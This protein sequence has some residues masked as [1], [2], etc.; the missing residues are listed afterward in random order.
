MVYCFAEF[1]FDPRL[2][3]LVSDDDTVSLRPQASRLLEVLITHAPDI[4]DG[5]ELLDEV[6]GR[7]ALSP[8]VVPQAISELRQ[9]LGDH[10]Q[11]P[12][13]IETRHRRGYRFICPV[14]EVD[15]D[16]ESNHGGALPVSASAARASSRSRILFA[17]T[18]VAVLA[19]AAMSLAWWR[20]GADQRWLETTAIPEFERLM[21][22]DM[23]QAWRWLREAR[24]R[25]PGDPL[26]EQLWLDL[27]LP[28]TLV[29]KPEGATVEVLDYDGEPDSWVPLGETPLV[30]VR[31]PLVQMRFHLALDGY[32]ALETAP[33]VLPAAEPFRLHRPGEAPEDMVF[34]PGGTVHYQD[35]VREVPDFWLDRHE[36]T[37]EDYL[38]FVEAGGYERPEYWPQPAKVDGKPLSFEAMVAG[39]V[40]S[41]GS[42]GPATWTLGMYPQGEANRPVEGI[43]WYEAAAYAAFVDKRLPTAFH[44]YRAAG[45]GTLP[46]ANFSDVLGRSN[47]SGRGATDVGELGGQGPYGTQDMAGNV[48]E[49]VATP[50]GELRHINGGSWLSNN[51]RFRD[52]DA[53]PPLERR[54]GFGVRL[55]QQ[56]EPVAPELLANVEFTSDP[57][58]EPVDDETFAIYERQFDYDPS[59][60]EPRVE[61]VD[62]SH[63][64]WRREY[65]SYTGAYG[66]ERKHAQLLLPRH[67]EPP[68][69]VVVHFP[70]GDALLL[71]DSAEAGLNQVELFLRNGRA[72]IYP[73][74]AGTFERREW[75]ATGPASSRDLLVAQVRDLRRS[76]DYLASRP[77]IDSEA[78]LLHGLSYG[79]VRAPFALAVE[80]RIKAA[81]LVSVGYYL[82]DAQLPEVQLQD[83]LPRIRIPVLV[84]NGRDDFTFPLASSQEPFF[85]MLGAAP[86]K[87]VHLLRDWGHIPPY[88]RELVQAQLDWVDRWLGPA[89]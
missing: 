39:L 82:R 61:R 27:T 67:G 84:I 44:W 17:V 74:Y 30:D 13:F 29:S 68:Y 35:E 10:A 18:L 52:P 6:W 76:L 19:V 32:Q 28:V 9:A 87:K 70:G 71:G 25:L 86:G 75:V 40:D 50:A 57:V 21:E 24:E 48:A 20:S 69:Q 85:D 37:N 77:D 88:D 4:V 56:D 43:S 79:G 15:S 55:M 33:S 22:T 53:Q 66:S 23:F 65:V 80:D 54:P 59:P 3:T 81:I 58:P 26:L 7:R 51:Y 47:F 1:A 16:G 14:I 89:R 12:R 72:V 63:R 31:L 38:A 11:S 60:L 5:D 42:P 49:W 34:V 8:N 73:V 62:D 83:Y 41:S 46:L 45:L 78:I 36:V 2:G 64:E